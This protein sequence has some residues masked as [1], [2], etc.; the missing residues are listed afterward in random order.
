MEAIQQSDNGLIKVYVNSSANNSV[1]EGT[2]FV[3]QDYHADMDSTEENYF[4]V[5]TNPIT[6]DE[7]P[8]LKKT[9]IDNAYKPLVQ[10]AFYERDILTSQ[11]DNRLIRHADPDAVIPSFALFHQTAF[12][13][14]NNEIVPIIHVFIDAEFD[15]IPS[16][17]CRI[18]CSSIWNY[19]ICFDSSQNDFMPLLDS[20]RDVIKRIE[21]N[22]SLGLY[23]LAITQE[24]A[25]LNARLVKQAYI[26]FGFGQLR[27]KLLKGTTSGTG[28]NH[29]DRI[30]PFLFHS[31]Q[32]M[33]DKL[34]KE[35]SDGNLSRQIKAYKWRF[36]L[37]DDKIDIND[38]NGVL[39]SKGGAK[40][41]KCQILE[42]RI[43]SIF[44]DMPDLSDSLTC[45]TFIYKEPT[46]DESWKVNDYSED[47]I[48][49]CVENIKDAKALMKNNE[50][51]IIFLD[52]LLRK[53][54]H[55]EQEYGYSL[56]KE[57]HDLCDGAV[58]KVQK[59]REL[60][61]QIGPQGKFFFMFISA[62]TTAVSERLNVL[63]LSRNEEIW[64]IGEGACPTNTPE[65]FKYRL[66]HLMKR[67]LAQCGIN[68]LS[69][70]RILRTLQQIFPL[71]T[72]GKER[73][74]RI[75][76][77]RDEA[78]K[79]YHR[80]LGFHYDYFFMRK[81]DKDSRLVNSFMAN[82]VHLNA[83]LEH[84]LQLIHL[85]A[86]GTIRQWPEIWEE[87]KYFVRTVNISR[88]DIGSRNTLNDIS[89]AI[90]RYIIDLKSE[91]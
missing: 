45:R 46:F 25:D 19:S 86:F 90:E 32:E 34:R 50:F 84:L 7:R 40:V 6:E 38:E 78:Y 49:V 48:I 8:L 53:Y 57:L 79:V 17:F 77:V 31:E 80:I 67:R 41:T 15:D 29:G 24:Y 14:I 10:I 74:E 91:R 64:E 60:G 44:V 63:G 1:E 12:D 81:Y 88:D 75:N 4:E 85:T 42:D 22:K 35:N 26:S 43:R 83:M 58:D 66:I 30:A 73:E 3:D 62:F 68:D 71:E 39:S 65:L 27:E 21:H 23:D 59:M 11:Y 89:T 69:D 51:D 18:A 13:D 16:R 33:L 55:G 9:A 61:Y 37:V 20:L 5:L 54:E 72:S 87:Y 82:K 56:L 52:Y 2:L 76:S 28:D 47:I 70:E 36:L